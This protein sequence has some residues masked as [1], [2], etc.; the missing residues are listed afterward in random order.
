MSELMQQDKL[1]MLKIRGGMDDKQTIHVQQD[2][3]A[4][5]GSLYIT[6]KRG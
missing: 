4:T 6:G 5:N 3:C 1:I 2:F